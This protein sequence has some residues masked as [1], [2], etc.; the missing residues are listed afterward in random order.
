MNAPTPTNLV[1]HALKSTASLLEIT[2]TALGVSRKDKVASAR[3]D[4][5]QHAANG[6]SSL[7]V[8][9]LA[10]AR[11]IH[12]RFKGLHSDIRDNAWAFTSRWGDN[13]QRLLPH[14]NVEPWAA[15]HMQL[16]AEHDKLLE[17]L[18]DKADDIIERARIC[19]GDY[20]DR[21]DPPT[22]AELISAYTVNHAINPFPD[23][24]GFDS[25]NLPP[26]TVAM[27][28]QQFEENTAAAFK[29][30]QNDLIK[31]LADPVVHLLSKLEGYEQ[32]EKDL[33]AGKNVGKAGNF[34]SSTLGNVQ[35][36]LAMLPSLNLLNDPRLTMISDR[37]KL[38]MGV[39]AD[40]LKKSPDIR[41]KAIADMKSAFEDSLLPGLG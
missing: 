36:V 23:D 18:R 26:A 22:R 35:D 34:Q 7:N 6:T 16:I 33:A 9:R 2:T 20:A 41:A 24:A 12:D 17:E 37:L 8:N 11:D 28:K 13:S 5:D 19:L 32:R 3:M 15:R 25:M 1:S 39:S 14:T 29:Q 27:L 38:L 40:D 31:R 30:G 21:I 10:G 4:N